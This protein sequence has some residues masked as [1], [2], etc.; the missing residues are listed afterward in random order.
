[1]KRTLKIFGALAA[2]SLAVVALA[3]CSDDEPSE[4]EATAALC[5]DLDELDSALG[6][7]ADLNV[8]STFDD[9]E[10]AEEDVQEA[11]EAV[12]ASAEDVAD[13]RIDDLEAAYDELLEAAD[14]IASDDTIGEAATT[15]VTQAQSVNAAR[16]GLADSV[17][18]S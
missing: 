6:A 1:V 8:N 16:Q 7:Y 5:S 11:F 4:A 13:A 10:D 15:L 2:A 3:G 18:C 14:D 17:N 12:E 9:V